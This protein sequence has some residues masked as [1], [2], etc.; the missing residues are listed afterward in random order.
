MMVGIQQV[1]L[2]DGR[3]VEVLYTSVREVVCATWHDFEHRYLLNPS[4]HPTKL[5][6]MQSKCTKNNH[7]L[8]PAYFY[9]LAEN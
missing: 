2:S 7:N 6:S 5:P 9:V 4:F 1:Y 3:Q 8:K